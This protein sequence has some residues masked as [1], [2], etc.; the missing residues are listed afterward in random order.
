MWDQHSESPPE[1]AQPGPG[2]C[3]A[4]ATIGWTIG[5]FLLFAGA[6]LF[7]SN[8]NHLSAIYGLT[9]LEI[10]GLFI[11]PPVGFIIWLFRSS[12]QPL[13]KPVR[14][15]FAVVLLAV[16]CFGWLQLTGAETSTPQAHG[17]LLFWIL[18]PGI[19]IGLLTGSSLRP[20]RELIRGGEATVKGTRIVAGLTGLLLRLV[21][22]HMFMTSA[23]WVMSEIKQYNYEHRRYMDIDGTWIP[24]LFGHSVLGLIVVFARTRIEVLA[25]LT[26][27][28]NAP[29]IASLWI[30]PEMPNALRYWI[31]G[32]VIAWALF[33]LSR[34]QRTDTALEKLRYY[35][36]D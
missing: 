25:V 5:S 17:W 28:A 14:V 29:L 19:A 11:G 12:D 33:L 7:V 32:Y 24:I 3:V 21:V 36:I 23:L 27:I 4:Q 10:M 34:W 2:T 26:A 16:G 22:V 31:V 13:S 8:A 9:V 35:L 1:V 15:T 18:V 6:I 20:G 30:H